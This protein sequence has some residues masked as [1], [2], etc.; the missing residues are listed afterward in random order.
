MS[1]ICRH[2]TDSHETCLPFVCA[3]TLEER[4]VTCS[5][6]VKS[7]ESPMIR[8]VL[9]TTHAC[10]LAC[11]QSYE[12]GSIFVPPVIC[13]AASVQSVAPKVARQVTELCCR[14]CVQVRHLSSRCMHTE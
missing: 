12:V 1:L 7:K 2:T 4:W 13:C 3:S 11:M 14:W 5:D 8:L 9:A 6:S 10:L